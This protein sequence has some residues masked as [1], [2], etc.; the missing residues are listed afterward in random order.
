MDKMRRT[1]IGAGGAGLLASSLPV[2][3]AFAQGAPVK[4]G[5]SMPETGGLGAG[6]QAALIGLRMWVDD[7]NAKGGLSGRS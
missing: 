3:M 5:M 1:V 6:G 4:I 7:I 2:G